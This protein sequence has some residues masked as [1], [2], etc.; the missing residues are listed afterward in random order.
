M[1][2]KRSELKGLRCMYILSREIESPQGCSEANPVPRKNGLFCAW[3]GGGGKRKIFSLE[4]NGNF[5]VLPKIHEK[6]L[7]LPFFDTSF[8]TFLYVR[9]L[10]NN[11]KCLNT[12]RLK[13]M[14]KKCS[15]FEQGKTPYF[16]GVFVLQFPWG[17]RTL[18]IH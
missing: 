13:F 14:W 11:F 10:E 18:W 1:H 9:L 3:G 4:N 8:L 16:Q 12:D 6:H 7:L 2:D 5:F 15:L 17:G